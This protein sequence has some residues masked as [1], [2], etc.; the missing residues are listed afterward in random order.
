MTND[1]SERGNVPPN[2]PQIQNHPLEVCT[3]I[4]DE[5]PVTQENPLHLNGTDKHG[6]NQEINYVDVLIDLVS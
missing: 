2:I 1:S 4:Q 3:N 6:G 5:L